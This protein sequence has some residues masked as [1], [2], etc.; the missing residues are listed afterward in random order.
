M[1]QTTANVSAEEIARFG[2]LASRWWD[3]DGESRPLHDLNPARTAW[4]AKR[5]PLRDAHVADIGCGGG[6]L[7]ESLAR[8]G[9]R[10]TAIDLAP[11]LIDIATLHLHESNLHIDYRLCSSQQLSVDEPDSFDAVCCMELIEHVPDSAALIADLAALAK[12]G[13]CVF[14]STLNRTPAAFA[15]A[16]VGA[17]Y[18]ARLLPRGTHHYE[19]FLRPSELA[20]LLRDA[21]LELEKIVGLAYNPLTR[22]AWTIARTD[23]NYM[24][25]ARKS[26]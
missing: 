13:G 5:V 7:S 3:P 9:A 23:V 6:I 25:C 18:V 21:G 12:P 10:V 17:E 11:E 19:Q 24:V 15:L 8:A 16:I 20:A 26:A 22:K 4:I 1:T 14:L 2:K